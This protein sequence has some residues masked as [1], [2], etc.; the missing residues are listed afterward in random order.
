MMANQYRRFE[1][2]P[3]PIGQPGLAGYVAFAMITS[4]ANKG[5]P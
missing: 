1:L 5:L 4:R 2:L 3:K